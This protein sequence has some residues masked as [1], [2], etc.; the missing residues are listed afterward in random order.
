MCKAPSCIKKKKKKKIKEW[1]QLSRDLKSSWEN[2][3]QAFG[4]FGNCM[5]CKWQMVP[6]C[7]VAMQ[8]TFRAVT[9]GC[10]EPRGKVWRGLDRIL[11]D[12]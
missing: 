9:D 2:D 4:T 12:G 3:S 8:E 1:S 6:N 11:R 5:R 7:S 10:Q